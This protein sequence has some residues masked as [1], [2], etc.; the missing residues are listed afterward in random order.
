[1][2]SYRILSES[3]ETSSWNMAKIAGQLNWLYSQSRNKVNGEK[4]YKG[5]K[6]P[7]FILQRGE[8]RWHTGFEMQDS[9]RRDWMRIEA[10]GHLPRLLIETE[11]GSVCLNNELAQFFIDTNEIAHLRANGWFFR[12]E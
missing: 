12:V 5:R 6:F 2:N 8:R 1:M 3:G 9:C 10:T 4:V 7:S 11:W